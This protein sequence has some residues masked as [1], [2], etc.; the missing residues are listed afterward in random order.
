MGNQ[1]SHPDGGSGEAP[2]SGLPGGSLYSASS[3]RFATLRDNYTDLPALQADLRRAGLESSNL[4]VGIDFTKSNTWTGRATNGGRCLHDCSTGAPNPYEAALAII[5]KTLAPFDD[6]GLIP[7][8]GFGCSRS[9]DRCVVAFKP[10]DE[11]C[12]GFEELHARYRAMVGATNL[13]GPTSFGPLIRQAAS[14]VKRTGQYHIL[15]IVA[16]GQVTRGQDVPPGE[17]SACEAD[18]VAAIVEASALPLSIVLVGVGD[19]PW[20]MMKAFDDE[21]PQRKF[22]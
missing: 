1:A 4:I 7:V 8:Y 16:D 2:L 14:V 21:L 20:D 22:E 9:T 18:T 11:P 15:V 5:A 19:G 3:H 12:S 6:D 13:A 10:N 17:L